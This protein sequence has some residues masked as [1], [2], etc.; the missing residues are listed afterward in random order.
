MNGQ[1]QPKP[2]PT[3]LLRRSSTHRKPLH[4]FRLLPG[5]KM[6]AGQWTPRSGDVEGGAPTTW[7]VVLVCAYTKQVI[8]TL[9][10]I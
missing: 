5:R 2:H 8:R 4:K 9:R 10:R 1:G 6:G 7:N 3:S